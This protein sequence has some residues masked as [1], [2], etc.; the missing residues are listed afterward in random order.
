MKDGNDQGEEEWEDIRQ[1]GHVAWK[2]I[3]SRP[4]FTFWQRY[5]QVFV[6][7]CSLWVGF[8]PRGV[9]VS[10]FGWIG[11]LFLKS[12]LSRGSVTD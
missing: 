1:L 10:R 6:L 9:R 4:S 3:S 5:K 8:V 7:L 11:G 2:H 12:R